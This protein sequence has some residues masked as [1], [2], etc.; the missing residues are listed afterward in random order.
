MT[1]LKETKKLNPRWG[2]GSFEGEVLASNSFIKSTV[3]HREF[4]SLA[5]SSLEG[6][7]T[8]AAATRSGCNVPPHEPGDTQGPHS[9]TT[10]CE[11]TACRSKGWRQRNWVSAQSRI[12]DGV[13]PTHVSSAR[14]ILVPGYTSK[15]KTSKTR[16]TDIK[17]VAEK[18]LL[19]EVCQSSLLF[20]IPNPNLVPQKSQMSQ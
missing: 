13:I 5:H 3:F 14:V 19:T 15:W 7:R 8:D 9:T 1:D 16:A 20:F 4:V 12:W 6:S 18:K 11:T 10:G 17:A 2:N